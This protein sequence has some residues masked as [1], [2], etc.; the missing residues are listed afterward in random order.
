LLQSLYKIKYKK[1]TNMFVLDKNKQRGFLHLQL[2]IL[3]VFLVVAVGLIGSYVVNKSNAASY[4]TRAS[5]CTARITVSGVIGDNKMA[6]LNITKG[7]AVNRYS[8]SWGDGTSNSSAGHVYAA[9]NTSTNRNIR[10]L[11]YCDYI[12]TPTPGARAV[13]ATATFIQ[14]ASTASTPSPSPTSSVAPTP[15]ASI[16]PTALPTPTP[17]IEPP[18]TGC[19]IINNIIKCW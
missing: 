3:L 14:K 19:Q 1:V 16:T 13:V 15:T 9:V 18:V 2:V 8:V 17:T 11:F 7:T 6:V 4:S 10:A 5:D 12:K